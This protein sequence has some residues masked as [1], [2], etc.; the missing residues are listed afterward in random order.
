MFARRESS[1]MILE[2]ELGSL[3]VNGCSALMPPLA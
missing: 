2:A 1:V 3:V